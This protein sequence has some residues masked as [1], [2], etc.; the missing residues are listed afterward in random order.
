MIFV[1]LLACS[2]L[3]AVPLRAAQVDWARMAD[4]SPGS[5]AFSWSTTEEWGMGPPKYGWALQNPPAAGDDVGFRL[6]MSAEYLVNPIPTTV[7]YDVSPGTSVRFNTVNIFDANFYTPITVQVDSPYTLSANHVSVGGFGRLDLN[8]GTLVSHDETIYGLINLQDGIV[9]GSGAIVQTAGSNTISNFLDISIGGYDLRGGVL[10]APLEQIGSLGRFFQAGGTNN[11]E[12]LYVN[13]TFTQNGGYTITRDL[14][15]GWGGDAVGTYSLNDVGSLTAINEVVGNL[16]A[17]VFNQAGGTNEIVGTL[18][19]GSGAYGIYNLSGGGLTTS[20]LEIKNG[21]FN[22]SGGWNILGTGIVEIGNSDGLTGRYDLSGG[23]LSAHAVTVGQLGTGIFGH[24]GGAAEMASLKVGGSSGASGTY[25]LSGEGPVGS[26]RLTV[27]AEYIGYSG[28]GVFHHQ[29]DHVDGNHTVGNLY[30]GYNTG[31]D[32]SYFMSGAVLLEAGDEFVGSAGHGSF[33]Q[34]QGINRI[35]PI[36]IGGVSE[37]FGTLTLGDL[38]SG[39]GRY[40]MDPTVGILEL[41]ASTEIIGRGG[42]G[43]FTQFGG[44]N[45]VGTPGSA[46]PENGNL[47]IGRSAGGIGSYTL[48]GATA[49]LVAVNEYIGDAGRGTFTHSGGGNAL[50]GDLYLGRLAGGDGSY[51]L[52]AVAGSSSVVQSRAP[53]GFIVIPPPTLP[54][55]LSAVNEYIGVGGTAAFTHN[56]GIN[57]L[58]GILT[59]GA[60]GTYNLSGV[61]AVL[62]PYGGIMNNGIFNYSAGYLNIPVSSQSASNFTNNGTLNIIDGTGGRSFSAPVI[63]N[64]SVN[65][66][67]TTVTFSGV[68]TNNGSMKVTGST[69][70]FNGDFINNGEYNSDP[71]TTIAN[72]I[73]IGP[74]GYLIG[75]PGDQWIVSNDFE[76]RSTQNT[77]WNTRDSALQFTGGGSHTMSLPGT[78]AGG[79]ENNFAWGTLTIDEGDT[80]VLDGAAGGALYVGRILGLVFDPNDPSTITNIAGNGRSIFFDPRNNE[81]LTG[82]QYALSDGTLMYAAAVPTPIPSSV[83]LFGSGLL[84]LIG[85]GRRRRKM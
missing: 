61:D 5:F 42:T 18:K 56:S 37:G 1:G 74:T 67:G 28:I 62:S 6:S 15:I 65:A 27:G 40:S 54:P 66:T 22:Q 11:V 53:L 64:G 24:T 43:T 78:A 52:D 68:F 69:V 30:L 77:L 84:G 25:T 50:S 60:N 33:T 59:V 73:V 72:R 71:S 23:N 34:N 29:G 76:N 35:G 75:G 20:G 8:G 41:S 7:I 16:S 32:G 4:P 48:G 39:Y 85:I 17:G 57:M 70:T 82:L 83:L 81:S 31:A 9:I 45:T 3:A 26:T 13:G 14:L 10:Y 58:S 80:L 51:T 36:T 63:N 38:S 2:M 21:I 79:Y 47:Y 44:T 19:I 55:T 49:S 12:T 46:N